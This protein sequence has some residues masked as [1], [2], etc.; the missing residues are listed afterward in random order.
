MAKAV[1]RLGTSYALKSAS[2]IEKAANDKPNLKKQL[3]ACQDAYV[4]IVTSLK[5]AALEL[6]ESPDTA[7]YDVMVCTDSTVRVKDLVGKNRDMA[8]KRVITMTLKMEKILAIAVGATEAV[9]G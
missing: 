2:F 8:S 9:G 5:S 1:L 6:K 7:N 3:K 4:N